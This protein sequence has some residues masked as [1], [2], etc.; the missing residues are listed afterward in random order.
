MFFVVVDYTDSVFDFL[1]FEGGCGYER[2]GT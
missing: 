2:W 1:D